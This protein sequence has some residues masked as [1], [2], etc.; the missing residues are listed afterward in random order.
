MF[1]YH[2]MVMDVFGTGFAGCFRWLKIVLR[3]LE[4]ALDMRSALQLNM[5]LLQDL[6]QAFDSST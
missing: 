3:K 1:Y 4:C 2:F 6:I 5:F